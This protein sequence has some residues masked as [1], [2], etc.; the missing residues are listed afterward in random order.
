LLSR[1]A[2]AGFDV[3]VTANRNLEFQQNLAKEKLGITVQSSPSN[4][5]EDFI[6]LV[7]D[8]FAAIPKNR[9]GR[10]PRVGG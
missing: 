4:A 2:D 7:P 9:A 1:A 10:V 3:F 8:L 5:L 6:R